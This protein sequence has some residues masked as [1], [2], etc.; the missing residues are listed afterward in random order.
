[1][2]CLILVKIGKKGGTFYEIRRFSFH[3]NCHPDDV[4]AGTSREAGVRLALLHSWLPYVRDCNFASLTRVLHLRNSPRRGR[5][6][7]ESG[8]P[9]IREI[10]LKSFRLIY[11]I[12]DD[13]IFVLTFVHG[14]RDL[15]AL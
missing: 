14:A 10:F 2:V 4:M 3:C 7:P 8:A 15:T 11:Q 6:V 12:T 9:D 5:I 1:M 13:S